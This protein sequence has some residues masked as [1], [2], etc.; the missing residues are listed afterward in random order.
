[1]TEKPIKILLVD[2]DPDDV[3]LTQ[4]ELKAAPFQ[5]DLSTVHDGVEAMAFLR[6]EGEYGQAPRPDVILPI[7]TCRA[8]AA[9]KS[10]PKSGNRLN[11]GTFSW[12]C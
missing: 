3:I 12:W 6:R 7:S 8:R 1:M 11:S 4:E 9:A 2:D 10:W 5:S